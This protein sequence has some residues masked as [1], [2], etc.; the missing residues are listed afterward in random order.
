MSASVSLLPPALEFEA[1]V[2]VTL[3]LGILLV[4]PWDEPLINGI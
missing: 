4:P 1:Q 3:E 2:S